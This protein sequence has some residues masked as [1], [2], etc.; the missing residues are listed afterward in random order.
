VHAAPDVIKLLMVG[1]DVT[2]TASGL[3]YHGP[4]QLR[5]VRETLWIWLEEHGC[6]SVDQTAAA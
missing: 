5:S 2:M 3:L 6:E 1:A 4:E